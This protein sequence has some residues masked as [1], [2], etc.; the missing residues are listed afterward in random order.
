MKITLVIISIQ[1]II[2]LPYQ[3]NTVCNFS[4]IIKLL[5]LVFQLQVIW[6]ESDKNRS[7]PGPD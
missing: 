6:T 7:D 5:S 1:Q 3:F 4:L 2:K